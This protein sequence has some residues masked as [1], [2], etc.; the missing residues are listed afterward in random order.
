MAALTPL[1]V[2]ELESRIRSI[3]VDDYARLTSSMWWQSVAKL[4]QSTSKKEI[5][6]WLLSTA[7]IRETGNGGNIAFEDLVS[8]YT[9]I[10]TKHAGAALNLTRAQLEDLYNGEPGGEGSGLEKGT[11]CGA[12]G[13]MPSDGV[14]EGDEGEERERELRVDRVADGEGR[15]LEVTVAADVKLVEEHAET[16]EQALEDY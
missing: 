13:L 2:R 1:I 9:E 14:G 16:A 15:R 4:K 8:S 7:M 12:T 6:A 11:R 10:E 3:L 5:L